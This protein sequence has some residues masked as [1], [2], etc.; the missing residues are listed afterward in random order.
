MGI[1]P[2]KQPQRGAWKADPAKVGP[3]G[4]MADIGSHAFDLLRFTTGLTT[5]SVSCNLARFHPARPRDDYGHALIRCENGALAMI[6]VS[7]ISHGRLNDLSLEVDGTKGSLTWRQESPN[8]LV[9]RRFG[10]PVVTYERNRRAESISDGVRA[11]CRLP[12]GHPEGFFEALANV[13][14]DSFDDMIHRK[15]GLAIHTHDT[16]YANVYDGVHVVRFIRQCV[17]SSQTQGAWQPLPSSAEV[18]TS[19][20]D[21]P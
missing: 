3:S 5:H 18:K 19:Q 14:R 21:L 4:A 12:G 2:G 16:G 20:E 15:R 8:Q 13:Y 11:A 10:Q 7:Q 1:Q 9:L 17:V 6:T